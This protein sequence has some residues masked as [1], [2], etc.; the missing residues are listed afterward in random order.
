MARFVQ[1]ERFGGPEVLEVVEA[2]DPQATPG[3][4]VV[5]VRAAGVNPI[6]WK[7][8]SGLRPSAPLSGPRRIG[9]DAS[10]VVTAL[11]EGVSGWSVGDEVI[12]SG[13]VGTYATAVAV[14][15]ESLDA[16]PEGLGFEEA[17]ALGIPVSTAYQ[18]VVSLGV[19]EG[20]TFL[21]HAGAGAVGRAAVQFAL[22]RG[23][24]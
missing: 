9:S 16:L 15:P 8:R 21:V 5:A 17:A 3:S 4:V 14:A 24:G 23:A 2:P 6:E 11:G 12:V 10:G 7:I 13:A 19:A 20:S 1:Y 22:D 18:A